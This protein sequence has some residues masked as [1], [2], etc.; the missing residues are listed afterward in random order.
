M[1]TYENVENLN[2]LELSL[3]KFIMKNKKRIVNMTI[4]DLA[5]EAHVSTTTVLRLCKKLGCE[6]F[7]E[8][9]VKFKLQSEKEK[10]S[11]VTEDTMEL[12]SF[13]ECVE[14]SK[15]G[16]KVEFLSEIVAEVENVIFI[17]SGSS[18]ALAQYAARFL[19]SIGKFSV[20]MDDPYFP[21]NSRYY[22]NSIVIALSVS[23]EHRVIIEFI[24]KLRSE[25]CKIASITNRN[26]CTIAKISDLNLS[27]YIKESHIG[28]SNI[29]SQLPVMYIIERIGRK[30]M[31]R[32]NEDDNTML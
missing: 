16:E 22:E 26:D 10:T 23:G 3:Y 9:K 11:N 12:I 8:F 18:S 4:R 20:F 32:K 31:S 21:I 27:Y 2:E 7:S 25:G 5:N 6:G 30:V 24:N 13:M 28:N 14:N 17:G 19:S 29:T 1:F 15:L